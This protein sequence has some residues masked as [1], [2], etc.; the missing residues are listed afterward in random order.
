MRIRI[1]AEE[2]T[3]YLN[4]IRCHM[5]KKVK[6]K[7]KFTLQQTTKAQRGSRVRALLLL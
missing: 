7:V 1:E 5:G 4:I 6:V 3:D 2:A